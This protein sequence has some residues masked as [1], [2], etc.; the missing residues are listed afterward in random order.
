MGGGQGFATNI[1]VSEGAGFLARSEPGSRAPFDIVAHEAA[2]QWW[3][4]LLNPGEAPGGVVLSEGMANYATILLHEQVYGDFE[5][6]RLTRRLEAEYA[7]RHRGGLESTMVQ[8]TG[9]P[10]RSK[11]AWV[12]WM[13]Q[14][15]MGREN[16]L[17][18]LRAFIVRYREDPDHPVIQDMLAVLRDFAPDTAGFDDFAAQWFFDAVLPEYRLSGVTKTREGDGW[19]VRGD[20]SRTRERGGWGWRWGQLPGSGGR[21]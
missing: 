2:H 19:V 14:Q 6:M 11:G 12:M 8:T 17:A 20:R 4:N 15:E 3:G 5:R 18:G 7:P 21:R 16:I 13:L 10:A 9:W 1:V